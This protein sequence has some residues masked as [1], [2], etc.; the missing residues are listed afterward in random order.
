VLR[1][2]VQSFLVFPDNLECSLEQQVLI[3]D[4]IVKTVIM[5]VHPI[6]LFDFI[7]KSYNLCLEMNHI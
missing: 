2:V 1:Y 5:I 7:K 4:S 6:L 3:V